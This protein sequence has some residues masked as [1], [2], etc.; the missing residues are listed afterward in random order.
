[1]SQNAVDSYGQIRYNYRPSQSSGNGGKYSID[2][3]HFAPEILIRMVQHPINLLCRREDACKLFM[4]LRL[5]FN[6]L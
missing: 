3:S 2:N 4:A 6:N 5:E 1:M